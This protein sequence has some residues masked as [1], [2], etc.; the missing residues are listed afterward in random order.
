MQIAFEQANVVEPMMDR[1]GAL[2]SPLSYVTDLTAHN[3]MF[4]RAIVVLQNKQLK[5]SVFE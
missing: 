2:L 1:I 5:L 4:V 3:K